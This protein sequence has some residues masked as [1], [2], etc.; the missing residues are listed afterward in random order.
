MT[1]AAI[2]A[3]L[4]GITVLVTRPQDSALSRV[5]RRAGARVVWQPAVRIAHDI[6]TPELDA[7]L[8]RADRF[9]WIVFTSIHG[10]SAFWRRA[11]AL[12]IGRERIR[13][14]RF[15]AVGPATARAIERNGARV[16]VIAE[17][18]SAEG[19]IVQMAYQ[20]E[21]GSTVLYPR[22]AGARP[23]L[24]DGL[25]RLGARV[26]DA[27]AYELRSP[28]VAELPAI[29]ASGVNCVVFCSPSAV[30]AVLPHRA[31]IARSAIACIGPTTA[32]AATAAGL[33]AQIVP[34]QATAAALADAMIEHFHPNVTA[35]KTPP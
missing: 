2:A 4:S 10:V 21:G 5:L 30:H 9:D 16:S 7:A 19:L 28:A 20:L 8:R 25:R 13:T 33:R 15:A 12:Q 29:L 24:V 1:A 22:T 18:H 17:P 26:T 34:P 3:P 32:A 6:P 27:T 14:A 11:R 31:L 23:I 35:G